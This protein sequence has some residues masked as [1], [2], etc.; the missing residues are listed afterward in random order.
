MTKMVQIAICDDDPMELQMAF[1]LLKQYQEHVPGKNFTVSLFSSAKALLFQIE[2][3]GGYDLYILDILMPGIDGIRLGS[4]LRSRNEN[5]LIIYLSSSPNYAVDSYDTKA[6][7]YLLK[8][9][10]KQRFFRVIGEAF[11]R[12]QRQKE[13]MLT[14]KT[15]QSVRLI[16]LHNILY[17]ELK[18][19]AIRYYLEDGSFLDSV[20]FS[21]SFKN[22]AAPLLERQGFLLLGSS[23]VINLHHVVEIG[24]TELRLSD[25]RWLPIPRPHRDSVKN[26]WMAYWLDIGGTNH[27]V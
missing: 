17:A 23:F 9:V 10:D 16:P 8:P 2:E 27:A 20:T 11:V 25:G 14:V 22:E 24:K 1:D 12:I 19:R 7:Y 15:P 21:G 18:K 5:G 4:I 3:S 26:Q 13:E 6:F